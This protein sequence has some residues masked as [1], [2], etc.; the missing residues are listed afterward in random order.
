[1]LSRRDQFFFDGTHWLKMKVYRKIFHANSNKKSRNNNNKKKN[2]YTFIRKK[3]TR[4]IQNYHKKQRRSLHHEK[5][6]SS[7]GKYQIHPKLE[8]L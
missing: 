6:I 1:M 5:M 4:L 7:I 8:P 3:K 2:S